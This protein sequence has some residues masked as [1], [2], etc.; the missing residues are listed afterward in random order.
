MMK[1]GVSP[2][3][4]IFQ[5]AQELNF[6]GFEL[7]RFLLQWCEFFYLK[8]FKHTVYIFG[9]PTFKHFF[10]SSIQSLVVKL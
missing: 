7:Q 2:K 8:F 9:V 3:T 5:E 6:S 10:T 4:E 1:E